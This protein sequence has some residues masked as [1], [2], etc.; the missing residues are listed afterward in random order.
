[1]KRFTRLRIDAMISH[2]I[3]IDIVLIAANR[4]ECILIDIAICHGDW[5]SEV[6]DLACCCELKR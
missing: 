5:D 1:M 2:M 3:V 6:V 4:V